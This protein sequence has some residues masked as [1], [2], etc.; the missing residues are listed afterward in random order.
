VYQWFVFAH[1]VG[2]VVFVFA[3]GTSAFVS[4]HIRSMRDPEVVA[5]Y[6]RM[7]NQATR[8]ATIGLIVLLIGGA[9]AATVGDTWSHPWVWASII[10]LIVVAVLMWAVGAAYYYPLRDL[11][12]GKD[13]V[14]PPD[15]DALAAQLDSRRP[16][17]LAL[18]GGAGLVILVWLMAVKPF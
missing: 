12:A 10:V 1:L 8:V 11:L 18:V 7:S 4:F 16:D 17:I 3:H 15:G 2:L 9:G 14:P 6:L 13:G 5:D